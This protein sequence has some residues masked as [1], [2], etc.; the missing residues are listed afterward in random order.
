MI[1]LRKLHLIIFIIYKN[2]EKN[3]ELTKNQMFNDF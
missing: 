3:V 1:I 2:K